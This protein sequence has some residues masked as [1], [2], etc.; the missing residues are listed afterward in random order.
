MNAKV[1]FLAAGKKKVGPI[2]TNRV[3][4]RVASGKVPSG[5]L[6]WKEGMDEWLP[7]G[8]ISELAVAWEEPTVLE[9]P[10]EDGSS[11]KKKKKKASNGRVKAKAEDADS[12]DA[13]EDTNEKVQLLDKPKKKESRAKVKAVNGRVTKTKAKTKKAS[14]GTNAALPLSFVPLHR[15]ERKDI[16]RSFG[17]G[18]SRSRVT[19][20]LAAFGGTALVGGLLSGLGALAMKAHVLLALPF[21]LAASLAVYVL[22]CLGL[23]ALSYSSRCQ[24]QDREAPTIKE[25]L[26]FA[27]TNVAALTVTPFL[28]SVAWIV[29][30]LALVLITLMVKIP[31]VGPVGTGALFGIHIALSAATLF[32]VL[33]AGI[34]SLYTPVIVGFEETGIKGTF[35][36]LLDFVK[37]ST[38]RIV[39]WGALPSAAQIPFSGF[40]IGIA[41]AIL[42]PALVLVFGMAGGPKITHWLMSMGAG[43]PPVAGLSVGIVPLMIWVGLFVSAV[44]AV[45]ASVQNSM[46][47]LLYLGG[48]D[49]NDMLIS[50]DAYLEQKMLAEQEG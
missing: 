10:P 31:Y 21:S 5:A 13:E 42:F 37:R 2:S 49:G 24:L 30:L 26:S 32:L 27:W 1:W 8:D 47:S 50:R 15:I 48:R 20:T 38:A 36:V 16:W 44:F 23:G 22:G 33:T 7:I 40:V 12:E 46:L 9:A 14:S 25:A 11:R 34:G 45:L 17:M 6:A 3:L 18:L 35:S 43:E 41:A 28:L 4:K 19:L 29:P 39:F